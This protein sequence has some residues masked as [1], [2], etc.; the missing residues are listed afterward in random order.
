M[1]AS[2]KTKI[3]CTLGPSSASVPMLTKLIGA[4]MDVV[5]LNFSHGNHE[6]HL[7]S[8]NNVREAV[9]AAGTDVGILQ[10]LQGPKIRIGGLSV[11]SFMLT[12]G[13]ALT[14]TTDESVVG[15]P[16]RVST[17]YRGLSAD[18]RPGEDILIDDGKLQL[19]VTKIEGSEV[20]CEVLVGGP[21]SPHK[22][23]NLPGVAVSAPSMT[24]KDLVDLKFG[25][26]HGVDY[27]ALSFVRSAADVRHLRAAIKTHSSA[28]RISP[29][30]I[31]AKIEKPQA[32]SNIDE[33]IRE[34]DGIMVARGDLGVELPPEDVP[35]L[36]KM[37]IHRCNNAGKPVIV[38][39]QMLE[40]MI[41]NPTPTRAEASDVA[42][43]VVDGGDA[44][45]LSGETSVGKYPLE[46]V[47]IMERIIRKVE[48]ERLSHN[49]DA[50]DARGDEP[51][52]H[53]A[54]GRSACLLADQM[55]AAAIVTVTNSGQT[56]KVLSRYR[57][58]P[59]II[60]ITDNPET[61][62]SLNVIWGVR[63]LLVDELEKDSDRALAQVQERLISSGAVC[64]GEYIVLLAGQPFFARGSTNF[65]K[66]ER[67]S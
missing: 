52:R 2:G 49:R 39:T 48:T 59:P 36:Q 31:I 29:V 22:G 50:A 51:D 18:V 67:M 24:D 62:R 54:L 11:P 56:A 30:Q 25:L 43:A 20:H 34:A 37:I 33:I 27:V 45:M 46:A 12:A 35:V 58:D 47:Q 1:P 21:L 14:I 16:G 66:V 6:E 60:A 15:G 41:A 10:D 55:H 8:M 5:R 7:A 13:D 17:T 38:A 32:I 26:A 19:R 63:G 61:L 44:V 42:N 65:I 23:I 4:G 40:S 3:V 64:R 57:P 9:K 53:D 28:G